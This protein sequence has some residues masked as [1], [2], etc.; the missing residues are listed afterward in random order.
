MA[1]ASCPETGPLKPPGALSST[2]APQIPC[3]TEKVKAP[4]SGK[5]TGSVMLAIGVGAF[6]S[7][8]GN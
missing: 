8:K 1:G 4:S 7:T 6:P 2:T 3:P 5:E